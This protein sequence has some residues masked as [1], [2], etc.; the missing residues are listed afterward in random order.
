MEV[1]VIVPY[2]NFNLLGFNIHLTGYI[3]LI[4]LYVDKYSISNWKKS[5]G[6]CIPKIN[7]IQ[8]IMLLTGTCLSTF[9]PV[10][11]YKR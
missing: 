10:K 3:P 4:L 1:S 8:E 11:V 9:F 2:S 6:T 5:T 7:F